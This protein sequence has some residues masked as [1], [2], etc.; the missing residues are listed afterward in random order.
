MDN[1]RFTVAE[2]NQLFADIIHHQLQLNR[3]CIHGE[4]TQMKQYQDH[5]YLT[6]SFE[7]SHLPVAIYSV[8]KKKLPF[9]K[10]GD[11]C[12]IIGEC[13][14]LKNKGQLMFSGAAILTKGIGKKNTDREKQIKRYNSLGH[15]DQKLIEDIPKTIE[16]VALITSPE[17]A[18]F[19]DIQSIISKTPH[20]FDTIIIPATMQ[21]LNA[22]TEIIQAL[23]IADSLS[24]DLICI[25][26]GGGAEEDFDCYF[27]DDVANAML[28]IKTPI[29][30]GIGHKI[31]I[32]LSCLCS[33]ANFETP[34]AMAQWLCETSI[35][36]LIEL[37]ASMQ[38]VRVQLLNDLQEL[39][40]SLNNI[41]N[42]AKTIMLDQQHEIDVKVASLT[43]QLIAANPLGRI[44]GGFVYAETNKNKA[45]TSVHQIKPND[46]INLRATDGNIETMVK[47][48]N[49]RTN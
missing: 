3:L 28:T 1:L 18:A 26:R 11:T 5:L 8:S 32:T 4:I 46:M 42:N 31:N 45:L 17:S 48:V 9:I 47:H 40:L 39:H 35:A 16:K 38:K 37:E 13:R 36:P 25:S 49:K 23:H 29:I 24:P 2:F 7:N 41:Q 43:E 14:Y 27:S 30:C 44:S 12:D 6:L 21:G 10:K 33:N 34:T 19:H 20:T 15:F 22:P